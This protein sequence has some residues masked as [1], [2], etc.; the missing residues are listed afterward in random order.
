L[1]RYI[2]YLP[3]FVC[4]L[5][6]LLISIGVFAGPLIPYQDPPPELI[7]LEMKQTRNMHDFMHAGSVVLL[8]GI[9]WAIAGW[10]FRRVSR[11]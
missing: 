1:K 7:A 2:P 5:G 3:Y 10:I 6:L 4:L 9:I 11:R 8:I